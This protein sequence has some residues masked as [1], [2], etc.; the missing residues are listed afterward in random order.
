M[1]WITG[2]ASVMTAL[3]KV[4]P[5]P[6]TEF[7]AVQVTHVLWGSFYYHDLIFPLFLFL[8]GVS[9]PFPLASRRAHGF[10]TWRI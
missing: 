1:L 9:W 2:G 5:L 4:F 6:M 3:A 10:P 7:L 8:P